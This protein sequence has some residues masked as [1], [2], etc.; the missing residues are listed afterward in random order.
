M[1]GRWKTFTAEGAEDGEGKQHQNLRHGFARMDTDAFS[2]RDAWE[3][4]C[5]TLPD[6]EEGMGHPE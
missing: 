6:N 2:R 1:E 3:V 4:N 5:P